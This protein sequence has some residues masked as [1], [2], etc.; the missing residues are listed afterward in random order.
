MTDTSL[1][2]TSFN[3]MRH[4]M[5]ASQ[6]RTTAVDDV[7]V[8]AA[9]ARIP[10]EEFLPEGLRKHAYRDT[11]IALS[12]TRSMNSPMATGRLLTEAA[13]SEN[14]R[15][16][17]I[18]AACGYTAALV[19]VLAG[20]V[21]A[22]EED[23]DLAQAARQSLSSYARASLVEGPLVA[24]A[25][26]QAPYDILVIDGAVAA[27]PESLIAQVRPGGRM[28]GGLIDR[29][30]TRLASGTRSVGGAALVAFADVECVVLPGFAAAPVFT[31]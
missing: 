28:V 21:V 27:V 13:I 17:L 8:V 10:R 30:V 3:A 7:R 26:D 24:G 23:A 20:S 9:M 11:A 14:D 22:V 5:V 1:N 16:L 6:L 31:F 2:T 19:A 25:P 12:P 15:V 4:A 29:G 18:G